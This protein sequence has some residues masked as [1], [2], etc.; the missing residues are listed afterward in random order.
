MK[1]QN[2]FTAL[3]ACVMTLMALVFAAHAAETKFASTSSGTSATVTFGPDPYTQQEVTAVLASSDS[4]AGVVRYYALTSS[5]NKFAVTTAST[6][7][8]QIVYFANSGQT[9]NTNDVVV[10]WHASGRVVGTTVASGAQ[11]GQVTLATGI[12]ETGTTNDRVYKLS[13]VGQHT[14]GTT[15]LNIA[16]YTVLTVPQDSPLYAQV[17]CGTNGNITVTKRP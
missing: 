14:I 16:G 2:I 1:P 3:I 15:A 5:T 10:Y 8:A 12:G 6:S 11:T 17:T 9:V 4:A 7:G 13:Q